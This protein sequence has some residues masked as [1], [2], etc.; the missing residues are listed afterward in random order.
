MRLQMLMGFYDA[1]AV[2]AIQQDNVII[3][4]T[5]KIILYQ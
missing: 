4:R 1:V 5:L 3:I 2:T